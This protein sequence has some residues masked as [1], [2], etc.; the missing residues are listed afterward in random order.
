MYIITNDNKWSSKCSHCGIDKGVV[1]ATCNV[2]SDTKFLCE[3]C[4][5]SDDTCTVC[6]R[7]K[8]IE[9]II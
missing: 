2:C 7:D 5:I 6:N 3:W 4:M 1:L 9:Q 8:K